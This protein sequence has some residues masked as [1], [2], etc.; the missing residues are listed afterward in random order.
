MHCRQLLL[1]L[2]HLHLIGCS[3]SSPGSQ[4]GARTDVRSRQSTL[5]ATTRGPAYVAECRAAGVPVPDTIL[6]PGNGWTVY[7]DPTT[8]GNGLDEEFVLQPLE[9]E[10]WT[11]RSSSPA[12]ICLALPRWTTGNVA[13]ALG[14][15]C[16][17]K[18]SSRACFFDNFNPPDTT[19]KDEP[20]RGMAIPISR[21]VG[22]LD[23]VDKN[24]GMCT[25]CHRG[26]GNP[27]VIH[28]EKKAFQDL[29]AADRNDEYLQPSNGWYLPIVASTWRQNPGPLQRIRA[30]RSQR[31]CRECHELPEVDSQG[32]FCS[33][34]FEQ[35]VG[36]IDETMPPRDFRQATPAHDGGE[37]FDHRQ[38]FREHID[39]IRTWCSMPP[40]GGDYE[41]VVHVDDPSVL[42]PPTVVAPYACSPV[43][44]VQG[45]IP[46]ATVRV[47][48]NS[49]LQATVVNG[50]WSDVVSVELPGDVVVTDE[51]S[52]D[53]AIGGVVSSTSD[54]VYAVDYPGALPSPLIKPG[55]FHRCANVIGVRSVSGARLTASLLR[56]GQV[57][58]TRQVVNGS[59]WTEVSLGVDLIVS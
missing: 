58:E 13:S 37:Y 34:I 28:P 6:D 42:S 52:A 44:L 24:G 5:Y 3:C 23:L 46:G 45:V 59:D 47:F 57:V 56:A 7:R 1:A 38:L 40:A 25:D 10:L 18:A 12:G 11:W 51:F 33:E 41:E 31:S 48:K 43:C 49:V 30:Y 16:L 20:P 26:G 15:I 54:V 29:I 21:L 14:V 4:T 19:K 22:G 9:A 53:Q 32:G 27:F 35:S 2:I 8:G 36:R 55:V 50:G 39:V 17:G